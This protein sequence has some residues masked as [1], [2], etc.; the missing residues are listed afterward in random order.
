MTMS[1]EAKALKREYNRKW[2]KRNA[3]H[4]KEYQ[5]KW[6]SENKEKEA[7]YSKH[8]WEKQANEMARCENAG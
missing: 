3:D 1:E 2:R 5:R 8:Y 6:R 7:I 4:I